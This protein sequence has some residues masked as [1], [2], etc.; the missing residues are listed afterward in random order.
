MK[1]CI[2]NAIFPLGLQ[3]LERKGKKFCPQAKNRSFT[4]TISNPY[5]PLSGRILVPVL[6][7]SRRCHC[8]GR[9]RLTSG[10]IF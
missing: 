6:L 8:S 4:S 5:V 9:T 1:F 10:F 7:L 2:K 3:E